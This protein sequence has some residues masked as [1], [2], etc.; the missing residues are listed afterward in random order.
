M[1]RSLF[2]SG[3]QEKTS[4]TSGEE[5]A[6]AKA[7]RA[8]QERADAERAQKEEAHAKMPRQGSAMQGGKQKQA[9]SMTKA[10]VDKRAWR[11]KNKQPKKKARE[12]SAVDTEKAGSSE[13]ENETH[14]VDK[15]GRKR[16]RRTLRSLTEP[17]GQASTE[18]HHICKC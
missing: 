7:A 16:R 2:A 10:A 15:N 17:S 5:L 6:A 9:P 3:F 11:A 1:Q 4:N 13:F 14:Y 12:R 8:K 18:G